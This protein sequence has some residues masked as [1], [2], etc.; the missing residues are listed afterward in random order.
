[1]Q[2]CDPME[3]MASRSDEKV[4]YDKIANLAT[5][6]G[7]LSETSTIPKTNFTLVQG[8][9][10]VVEYGNAVP[11]TLKL[12]TL[13]Q[14]SVN[15]AVQMKLR[16]DMVT[17]LD[18]AAAAEFVAAEYKAVCTSTSSTVFTTDG[19]AT[20]TAAANMSDRNVRDVIDYLKK[21]HVP[22][23]DGAN[24]ICIASVNSIRGLYDFFESKAINTTMKNAANGE[25]G[26]YYGLNH[27]VPEGIY[28]D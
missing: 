14:I 1:M 12:K 5:A 22:K 13:S 18:S 24:Y 8:S 19:T 15:E 2:F 4:Y 27:L 3:A 26:R 9:L 17:V 28:E 6:G 20:A 11:M 16:D 10:T 7:T 21:A 25:I 23:Y